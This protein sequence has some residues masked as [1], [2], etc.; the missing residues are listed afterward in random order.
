MTERMQAVAEETVHILADQG[1]EAG[2]ADTKG[3]LLSVGNIGSTAEIEFVSA[4]GD[5]GN[6]E[7][8]IALLREPA[9]EMP[10]LE[11][12]DLESTMNRDA[13]LRLLRHLRIVGLPPPVPGNRGYNRPHYAACKGVMGQ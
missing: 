3:L 9:T 12:P 6:L 7:D 13:S 5:T 4:P 10:E 1:E 8:R 2:G 11:L